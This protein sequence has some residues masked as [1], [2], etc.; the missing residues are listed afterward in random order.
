MKMRRERSMLLWEDFLRRQC[1]KG[2]K[3]LRRL[4]IGDRRRCKRI[5]VPF[6]LCKFIWEKKFRNEDSDKSEIFAIYY[7]SATRN[8]RA[9]EEGTRSF[10][11]QFVPVSVREH[12]NLSKE[13]FNSKRLTI[14]KMFENIGQ[15]GFFYHLFCKFCERKVCK[16]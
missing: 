12:F 1:L 2:S 7:S 9:D 15:Y 8:G 6:K 3:I 4:N 14:E 10:S 13:N 5:R 11:Y 16:I